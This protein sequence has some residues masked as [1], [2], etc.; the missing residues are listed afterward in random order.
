MAISFLEM[1]PKRPPTPLA[2]RARTL[3]GNFAH[4]KY[5]SQYKK[6]T[7]SISPC[8]HSPSIHALH[9][10]QTTPSPPLHQRDPRFKD[11]PLY[12][13]TLAK[14]SNAQSHQPLSA[15]RGADAKA[16]IWPPMSHDV[17]R[18]HYLDVVCRSGV[19]FVHAV[20]GGWEADT[21]LRYEQGGV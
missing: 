21:P 11:P 10:A 9:T 17:A 1:S 12:Q 16:L 19:L 6:E 18:R 3:R 7:S 5:E 2:S 20:G 4:S 14:L 15:L 8:M 13:P